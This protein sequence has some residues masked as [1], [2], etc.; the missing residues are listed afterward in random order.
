MKIIFGALVA[1]LLSSALLSS[2][3]EAR[4]WWNGVNHC[5]YYRNGWH[6]GYGYYHHGYYRHGHWY[7]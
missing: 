6:H 3:A 5:H 7:R 1:L 2:Q 4:C